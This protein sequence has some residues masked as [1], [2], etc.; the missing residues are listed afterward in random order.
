[1]GTGDIDEGS[2][3]KVLKYKESV[4]CLKIGLRLLQVVPEDIDNLDVFR[5]TL[6]L[7]PLIPIKDNRLS[8]PPDTGWYQLDMIRSGKAF[9]AVG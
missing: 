9:P 5:A 2:E 4:N 7:S 3:N 1:M 8:V 6:L